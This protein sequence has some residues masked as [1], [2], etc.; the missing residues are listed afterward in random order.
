MPANDISCPTSTAASLRTGRP[1]CNVPPETER[2]RTFLMT[3]TQI[4]SYPHAKG[5]KHFGPIEPIHTTIL[6]Q[7]TSTSHL[8][9]IICLGFRISFHIT[10]PVDKITSLKIVKLGES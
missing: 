5:Y 3:F 4:T 2:F 8:P 9:G 10:N 1:L 7:V 6:E